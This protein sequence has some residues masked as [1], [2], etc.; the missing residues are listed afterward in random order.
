MPFR[1]PRLRTLRPAWKLAERLLDSGGD[2]WVCIPSGEFAGSFGSGRRHHFAAYFEGE[3]TVPARSVDEVCGFLAGCRYV[4]D[5]DLFR[6]PDYWQ[7]PLTFEQLRM[8]DCEDHALWAWRKL[9]ELGHP[10]HLV[11]GSSD[12]LSEEPGQ[13]AW[14]LFTAGGEL[15]LFETT[16][17]RRER[18]VRPLDEVRAAYRPHLSVDHDGAMF[19]YGGFVEFMA[20]TRRR[21]KAAKARAKGGAPPV[22][23]HTAGPPVDP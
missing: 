16:A 7:H 11:V 22:D 3:S 15:F 4:R 13:H 10:A 8:G 9:K 23:P 21:R 14:V 1:I 20:E 17:G 5:P 12:L 2:P 6:E 19:V 18:M